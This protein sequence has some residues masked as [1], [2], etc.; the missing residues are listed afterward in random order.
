MFILYIKLPKKVHHIISIE[1]Y[2]CLCA[3]FVEVCMS[4]I[5]WTL[6]QTTLFLH[7]TTSFKNM[8]FLTFSFRW[9]TVFLQPLTSRWS[10]ITS[11]SVFSFLVL[12]FSYTLSWIPWD[13]KMFIIHVTLIFPSFLDFSFCCCSSLC[14]CKFIK[15][16]LAEMRD[17]IARRKS[18]NPG[19]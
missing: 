16:F 2:I 12:K 15:C 17:T 3:V 14:C 10:N 18:P 13:C 19:W 1:H 11:S 6:N 9:A 4:M 7:I 8:I 5:T